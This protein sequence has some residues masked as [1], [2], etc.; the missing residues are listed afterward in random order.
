MEF[1][2]VLPELRKKMGLSQNELAD[3][4]HVTRQAVSRWETGETNPGVD[5]LKALSQLFGVS[6]NTLLGSPRTLICQSCG[7]PLTDEFLARDADGG[8][9]ENYCKWCWEDGHFT[10][11]FT[12]EEMIEHCVPLMPLGQTDPD[13]CRAYLR[14]ILPGLGRWKGEE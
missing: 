9:N 13:A 8:F 11:D 4:L 12:M 5:T 6:I 1:Q 3:R 10:Q 2:Q 14:G 7:M